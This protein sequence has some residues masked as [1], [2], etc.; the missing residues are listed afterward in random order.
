VSWCAGFGLSH[1]IDDGTYLLMCRR[2]IDAAAVL[3]DSVTV[4]LNGHT[5]PKLTMKD[6]AS[7]YAPPALANV[8]VTEDRIASYAFA[9]GFVGV[10]A[11][12]PFADVL[13]PALTAA[14]ASPAEIVRIMKWIEDYNEPFSISFVNGM[15]T[16]RGGSHVAAVMDTLVKKLH[17]LLAK[18]A[19]DITIPLAAIRANMQ[20]CINCQVANPSFDSQSKEQLTSDVPTAWVAAAV[21]DRFVRDVMEKTDI[22]DSVID[23]VRSKSK[24]VCWCRWFKIINRS[25]EMFCCVQEAARSLRRKTSSTEAAIKGIPKLEDANWAGTKHAHECTLIV[26]EGDSAKALAVAGLSVVGRDK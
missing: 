23:F 7:L 10:R 25:H 19:P 21:P 5:L 17:P 12:S 16:S 20:L 11:V 18:A 6:L 14:G 1:S 15:L 9:G 13:P 3:G 22:K 24:E 4:V 8:P 26:T 2:V